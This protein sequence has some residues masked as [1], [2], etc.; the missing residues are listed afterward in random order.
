M[1][2]RKEVGV[3]Q[4]KNGAWGFRYGV[5]VN[6]RT[7]WKKRS[8][9]ENGH[10][11]KTKTAAIKARNISIAQTQSCNK[12]KKIVCRTVSEI[13]QEYCEYSRVGRAYATIKKTR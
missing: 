10:P 4:L 2:K 1:Q 11:F 6:G 3:Y 12:E 8:K 9:D 7:V 13:Y 5:V